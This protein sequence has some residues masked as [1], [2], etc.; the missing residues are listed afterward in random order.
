M[1]T[2]GGHIF[3][4]VEVRCYPAILLGS[5]PRAQVMVDVDSDYSGIVIDKLTGS[6]KGIMIEMKDALEGKVSA[7][8]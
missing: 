4:F 5:C 1:C 3:V 8:S 2:Y 6:R 7:Q